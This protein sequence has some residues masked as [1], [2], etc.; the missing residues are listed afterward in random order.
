[1]LALGPQ[2][3][4][5]APGRHPRA[6]GRRQAGELTRPPG[7]RSH[8]GSGPLPPPHNPS[9]VSAMSDFII[10]LASD[11]VTLPN[12][13]PADPTPAPARPRPAPPPGPPPGPPPAP[14]PAAAEA[15]AGPP[16]GGGAHGGR[17]S[18]GSGPRTPASYA[19]VAVC[20]ACGH[21]EEFCPPPA[22]PDARRAGP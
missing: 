3:R 21:G 6:A 2:D 4:L 16:C 7:A 20:P 11:D 17:P 14:L 22:G 19:A 18:A 10:D 8:R 9:G 1:P 13:R 12:G 15:P 5:Q